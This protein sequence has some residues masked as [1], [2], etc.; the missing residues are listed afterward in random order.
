MKQ[1]DFIQK[2][3]NA[4]S[5]EDVRI[6]L[7]FV[8]PTDCST[9]DAFYKSSGIEDLNWATF[10]AVREA[11]EKYDLGC[12]ASAYIAT[13]L[14]YPKIGKIYGEMANTCIS[15]KDDFGSR[16]FELLTNDLIP[17]WD[18][19]KNDNFFAYLQPNLQTVRNA[20]RNE[21]RGISDY[22]VRT[23]GTSVTSMEYIREKSESGWDLPDQDQ[24]V[25][26]D[27]M[28]II[29]RERKLLLKRVIGLKNNEENATMGN[30]WNSIVCQKLFHDAN[31]SEI[32]IL[33]DEPIVN[34]LNKY[35]D[36]VEENAKSNEE[37]ALA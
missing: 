33:N 6:V 23:R 24:N 28:R 5:A 2:L 15:G 16:V 17:K 4:K 31:E 30:I 9:G 35:Y 36:W 11:E 1:D 7:G 25:E 22:M 20:I 37:V 12:F 26:E 27:V 10:Y 18:K 19:N 3:A 8:Y 21:D 13:S 29:E 14:A 34:A 32:A